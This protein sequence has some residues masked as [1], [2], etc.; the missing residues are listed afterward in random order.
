[1][2]LFAG[3]K[4]LREIERETFTARRAAARSFYYVAV[5]LQASLVGYMVS[6]FFG[7]VAY[8]WNIYYLI[9]YAVVLRRLYESGPGTV[10]VDANST[11]SAGASP[12]NGREG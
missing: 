3:L 11:R 10:N 7:S 2:F 4:G 9:S 1:M 5:G 6:S 8:Q 12:G